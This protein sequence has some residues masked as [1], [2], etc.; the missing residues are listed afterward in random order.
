MQSAPVRVHPVTA[1]SVAVYTDPP[2]S[3]PS[4]STVTLPGEA[5][6]LRVNDWSSVGTPCPDSVKSKSWS[7]AP[8]L[9]DLTTVRLAERS[10][11]IKK[12]S[13]SVTLPLFCG[14]FCGLDQSDSTVTVLRTDATELGGLIVVRHSYTHVPPT[15]SV[16][17][18]PVV[19]VT[20]EQRSSATVTFL[21]SSL[22]TLF[23]V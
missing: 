2:P 17:P 7:V 6:A 16:V 3:G 22:P 12:L 11:W 8:G 10:T 21:R 1:A 15:G 9:V 4:S 23:T 5:P 19:R 13:A 18:V 20:G 14:R